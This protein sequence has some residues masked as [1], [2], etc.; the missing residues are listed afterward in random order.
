MQQEDSKINPLT[1]REFSKYYKSILSSSRQLPVAAQRQAFLDMYH[2]N[3][4]MI[5]A[6]E[7]GSGKSTQIPKFVLYD[8][9]VRYGRIAITQPRRLATL[10]V[11]T[12]V[13][14]ELDVPLGG[15]VGFAIS[16]ESRESKE[17]RLSFCTDGLLLAGAPKDPTFRGYSCIII[18]EVHERSM[19]TDVLLM[20]LKDA[21]KSRDDLR[22]ILMSTTVQVA[23]FQAYFGGGAPMLNVPGR[24]YQVADRYLSLNRDVR[25][26]RSTTLEI[27][28]LHPAQFVGNHVPQ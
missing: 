17:T 9:L 10:S 14:E 28:Q 18:D 23:K 2:E 26:D 25:L 4:V 3:K 6:S 27:T 24:Q 12:R 8:Q 22:V 5:V 13:A 19:Q 1:K 16:L 15:A 20:M 11:A 21:F 7:T